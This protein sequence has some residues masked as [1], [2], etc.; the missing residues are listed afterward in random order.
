MR[1][2]FLACQMPRAQL[3]RFG[4]GPGVAAT[5]G[6]R[7]ARQPLTLL[8]V[9][10]FAAAVALLAAPVAAADRYLGCYEAY[11]STL[12]PKWNTPMDMLPTHVGYSYDMSVTQCAYLAAVTATLVPNNPVTIYGVMGENGA[13]W[14]HE[15]E[16]GIDVAA[17]VL[18]TAPSCLV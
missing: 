15:I 14:L 7:A 11:N 3:P 5:A 9:L 4:C 13:T 2:A 10:L 8:L 17:W 1:E 12:D 18:G 16:C 6:R